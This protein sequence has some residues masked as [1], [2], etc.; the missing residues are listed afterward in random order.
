MGRSAI[1]GSR[2]P[3]Q[4][5][6]GG[7]PLRVK[8]KRVQ[9]GRAP[10]C[11]SARPRPK[12]RSR[13]PPSAK[14]S[15]GRAH[16]GNSR[17]TACGPQQ[18]EAAA[19]TGSAPRPGPLPRERRPEA[20]G[21]VGESVSA[22]P[23]AGRSKIVTPP[24]VVGL[25]R[26]SGVGFPADGVERLQIGDRRCPRMRGLL[27]L[28]GAASAAKDDTV[29]LCKP[30]LADSPCDV[31]FSTTTSSHRGRPGG[32]RRQAKKPKVDCF[33]VYPTVSDDEGTNSD[34]RGRSGGA[35]D[36]ALPGGP[37]RRALPRLRADVPA[38]HAAGAVLRRADPAEEPATSA[39]ATSSPPGRPI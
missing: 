38:D 22:L 1:A 30:G 5:R 32:E 24:A 6:A 37:L 27:L 29:W 33:Y 9:A 26:G 17:S 3:R 21:L 10:G 28:P 25:P 23:H 39:T 2:G 13:T 34:S 18:D 16:P 31:D 15:G 7:R 14:T 36:R 19:R 20:D 11:G 12:A 35:L 4:S 8:P